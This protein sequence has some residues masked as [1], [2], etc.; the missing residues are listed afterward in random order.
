MVIFF[1]CLDLEKGRCGQKEIGRCP[2]GFMAA[3]T[4]EQSVGQLE[5][6][7]K[8]VDLDEFS[9]DDVREG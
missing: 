7:V 3:S 6:C 1:V 8:G 9:V 2:A 4:F 5:V